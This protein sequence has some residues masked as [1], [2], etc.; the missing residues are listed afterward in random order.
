MSATDKWPGFVLTKEGEEFVEQNA[1]LFKYDLMYNPL[2]FESWQRLG[3][4]YDEVSLNAIWLIKT[5]ILPN[6]HM[7]NVVLVSL[8]LLNSIK[9]HICFLVGP[10]QEVDLLLNDG[11]KH[12]NVVGWRKNPTLSERVETSRRRSRRCLLMSL[13]L[14][15]T[16]AQQV[17]PCTAYSHSF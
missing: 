14:A 6:F 12:I 8:N 9:F 2:R 15:K 3:N 13:A 16:S 17:S 4:I 1:K 11:S 10:S 5:L 7:N